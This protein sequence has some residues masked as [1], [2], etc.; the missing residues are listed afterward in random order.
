MDL[1]RAETEARACTLCA[2]CLPLG[3]RPMLQVGTRARLLA[4]TIN[5]RDYP[6]AAARAAIGGSVTVRFTV[7]TDGRARDCGVMRSSGD[8]ALDATTCRL[9]QRRF[10]YAPARDEAGRAVESQ[11]GWRQDWWL[12]PRG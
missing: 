6:A 4:G 7:G 2:P 12:E 9:I 8:I 3:P 10:R 1:K 11:Q 5:D